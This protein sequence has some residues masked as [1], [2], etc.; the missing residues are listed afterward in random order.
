[1]LVSSSRDLKYALPQFSHTCDWLLWFSYC[2]VIHLCILVSVY[3]LDEPDWP[4]SLRICKGMCYPSLCL[5]AFVS[6]QFSNLGILMDRCF[7]SQNK[8]WVGTVSSDKDLFLLP[9]VLFCRWHCWYPRQSRECCIAK[10][11]GWVV[12]AVPVSPHGVLHTGGCVLFLW[13]GDRIPLW[14]A[15]DMLDTCSALVFR[16]LSCQ[17]AATPPPPTPPGLWGKKKEKKF[18]FCFLQLIWKVQWP[19]TC[20]LF[21]LEYWSDCSSLNVHVNFIVWTR[22]ILAIWNKLQIV[23][24]PWPNIQLFYLICVDSPVNLQLQLWVIQVFSSAIHRGPLWE[25]ILTGSFLFNN[26]CSFEKIQWVVEQNHSVKTSPRSYINTLAFSCVLIS[27][28]SD[29]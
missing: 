1:M 21:Q 15:R 11:R 7:S 26:C 3:A 28:V 24:P 9:V 16:V 2:T 22:H 18:Q 5:F 19:A 25:G 8:V 29:L 17:W 12:Q 27:L 13:R 20:S 10:G 4:A 14:L 23:S 6:D